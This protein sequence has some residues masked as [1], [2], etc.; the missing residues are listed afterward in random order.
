MLSAITKRKLLAFY[1]IIKNYKNPQ[2][3]CFINNIL[4]NGIVYNINSINY[5][6]NYLTLYLVGLFKLKSIVE[7]H[8]NL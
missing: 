1:R 2:V 7:S 4:G 8:K 5:D 6:K 3:S